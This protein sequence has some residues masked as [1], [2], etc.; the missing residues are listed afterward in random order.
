MS[1]FNG[2]KKACRC[3]MQGCS[4]SNEQTNESSKRY[5][6]IRWKRISISS[7]SLSS[8]SE[9]AIRQRREEALRDRGLLPPLRSTTSICGRESQWD[10]RTLVEEMGTGNEL[11]ED[12]IWHEDEAR[13]VTQDVL[14]WLAEVDAHR[15]SMGSDISY[16][17]TSSSRGEGSD[18][19]ADITLSPLLDRTPD[20]C[21]HSM[22]PGECRSNDVQSSTP[23]SPSLCSSLT[24]ATDSSSV[25]EKGYK[26]GVQI[27]SSSPFILRPLL[28]IT[29]H[30]HGTIMTETSHIEDD[31][32]R[33]LTEL[34]YLA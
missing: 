1:F 19:S 29:I 22:R 16:A 9:R 2:V 26:E 31:E 32:S 14:Q 7:R 17:E 28:D 8:S 3:I 10:A 33:R 23:S 6:N 27:G 24:C 21:R 15:G 5:K 20:D 4:E 30:S 12:K 11:R 13:P 25:F 18:I 34:A